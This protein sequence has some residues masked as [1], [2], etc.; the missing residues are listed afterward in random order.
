MAKATC[1]TCGKKYQ[2]LGKKY[3]AHV[4]DCKSGGRARKTVPTHSPPRPSRP[5]TG[6]ADDFSDQ[7]PRSMKGTPLGSVLYDLISK[8]EEKKRELSKLEDAIS[9]IKALGENEVIAN[10]TILP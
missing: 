6:P 8:R 4:R 3:E 10:P 1:G 5:V 7:I 9:T 2:R